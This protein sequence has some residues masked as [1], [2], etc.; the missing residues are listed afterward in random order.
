[1]K[2]ELFMAL[3]MLMLL[4]TSQALCV[5]SGRINFSTQYEEI[6]QELKIPYGFVENFPAMTYF[7]ESEAVHKQRMS[8]LANATNKIMG[9]N[10]SVGM[11]I[12]ADESV[13]FNQVYR[14]YYL[15]VRTTKG[16]MFCRQITNPDEVYSLPCNQNFILDRT[17]EIDE[18]GINYTL[19]SIY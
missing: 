9:Q 8:I 18:K 1:M 4:T 2:T 11:I 14:F 17:V 15:A 16:F 3:C 13:Q 19:T 6:A 5:Q 7:T 12:S 10:D